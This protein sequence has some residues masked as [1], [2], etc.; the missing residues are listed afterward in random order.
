MQY[1]NHMR[2]S[3]IDEHGIGHNSHFVFHISPVILAQI[4]TFNF[5]KML[6]GSRYQLNMHRVFRILISKS[7]FTSLC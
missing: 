2:T 4:D 7:V 5:T 3:V 6:L 1:Y